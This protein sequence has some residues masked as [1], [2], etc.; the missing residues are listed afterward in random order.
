MLDDP[1]DDFERVLA[2]ARGG[3]ESAFTNLFRSVQ[4][5]L[6]HY[7]RTMARDG[8]VA[9]GRRRGR[10]LDLGRARARPVPR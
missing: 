6:L 2:A 3:D 4:P 9:A 5:L 1:D 7:L 8:S 10:D